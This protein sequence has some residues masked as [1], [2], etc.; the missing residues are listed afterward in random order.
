MTFSD[1]Q[2]FPARGCYAAIPS[3]DYH[4][5]D[6]L[7]SHRLRLFQRSPAHYR[8]HLSNPEPA[9]TAQAF[10][11]MLHLAV[12]EPDV[13]AREVVVTDASSRTNAYKALVETH[14][15]ARV[16]SADEYAALH[17]MRDAL[18][19]HPA[20]RTL[21]DGDAPRELTLLF[22]REVACGDTGECVPLD[23]KS[24]LDLFDLGSRR[25][26]DVKSARDAS[27]RAFGRAAHD[28]G[29]LLQGAFY[30]MAAAAV[31]GL[32]AEAFEVVFVV[33]EKDPPY[34]VG[35]YQASPFQLARAQAEIDVLA[36]RFAR[37]RRDDRWP[38]YSAQVEPL[39]LPPWA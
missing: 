38:A 23:C 15:A 20:A 30:A 3:R 17:A 27:P 16:A 7:S 19:A 33:V 32:P 24:R 21:L 25:I 9:T 2:V 18:Y 26:V 29:Y 31:T 13:F 35:V 14:G 1:P 6:D 37:C 28:F 22:A 10:G 12:L 5:L 36:E 34:A 4:A 11:E 8:H 39:T